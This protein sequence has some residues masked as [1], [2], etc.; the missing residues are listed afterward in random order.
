MRQT[1][2]PKPWLDLRH[3]IR[4]PTDRRQFERATSQNYQSLFLSYRSTL[5]RLIQAQRVR[6]FDL[7]ETRQCVPLQTILVQ[8]PVDRLACNGSLSGGDDH[9]AI[10]RSHASRRIES[11]H[12]R[13][14]TL[15]DEDLSFLVQLRAG[16]FRQMAM[17][18][19]ASCREGPVDIHGTAPPEILDSS[20]HRLPIWPSIDSCG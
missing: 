3:R 4:L 11:E 9:L 20:V 13:F 19:I 10:R 5:P 17:N 14:Q 8:I 15:I 16:A 1:A 12:S 7:S 2:H 18:D 6:L